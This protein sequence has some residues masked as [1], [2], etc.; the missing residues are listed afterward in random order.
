MPI[1]RTCVQVILYVFTSC[2]NRTTPLRLF[3]HFGHCVLF[4]A[5]VD[6]FRDCLLRYHL[7]H[8][9]AFA[10]QERRS[11]GLVAVD[12]TG[13]RN[14]IVPSPKNCIDVCTTSSCR[15]FTTH[16]EFPKNCQEFKK[17]FHL[18]WTCWTFSVQNEKATVQ[19]WWDQWINL[20]FLY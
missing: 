19:E 7:Q 8:R 11:V 18:L 17:T 15:W 4:L 9:Q 5:E 3:C 14:V 20:H 13:L 12:A 6:F 10:L 16:S 1:Y 2:S